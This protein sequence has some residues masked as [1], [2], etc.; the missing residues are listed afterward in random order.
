MSSLESFLA[1]IDPSRTIVET[2]QRASQ[3]VNSFGYTSAHVS[4]HGDF[5]SLIGRFLWHCDSRILGTSHLSNPDPGFTESQALSVI[6]EL[7][8]PSGERVGFEMASTGVE[9][10]LYR[11]LTEIAAQRARYYNSNEISARVGAYINA[12]SA[13]ER[14][15]VANEY[16]QR[17]GHLLPSELTEDS[18]PSVVAA[19]LQQILENHP[20]AVSRMRGIGRG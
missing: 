16:V 12:L 1:T 7:Y 15:R 6:R 10:G 8:G 4:S 17:Y 11:V 13:D 19:R 18:G 14:I 2:E 9:G 20:A 3:A 5:V